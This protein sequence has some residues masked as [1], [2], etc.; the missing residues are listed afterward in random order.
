MQGD[1]T[2]FRNVCVYVPSSRSVLD[3]MLTEI[4]YAAFQNILN[5][6]DP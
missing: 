2:G 3:I 5:R 4:Y 6:Q 1:S